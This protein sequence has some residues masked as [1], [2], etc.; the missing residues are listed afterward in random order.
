VRRVAIY[1]L[2]F[3]DDN[4]EHLSRHGIAPEEV[5][6]VTGNDYVTARNK[7]HPKNRIVMIGRTDGGRMLTVVLET[8]RDDVVWRPITGWDSGPQEIKLLHDT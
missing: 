1:F 8:T 6:Q 5:E 4:T 3:D 7:R 2:E